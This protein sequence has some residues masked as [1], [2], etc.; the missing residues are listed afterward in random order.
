MTENRMTMINTIILLLISYFLL[1]LIIAGVP[2]AAETVGSD[3]P[4][5]Q[6]FLEALFQHNVDKL[7]ELFKNGL[8]LNENGFREVTVFG[9]N[10]HLSYL[11][12]AIWD[13]Q[14][15]LA[16]V[17]AKYHP[18]LINKPCGEDYSA[19]VYTPLAAAWAKNHTEL[20][21]ILKQNVSKAYNT[22]AH[23]PERDLTQQF[24]LSEKTLVN[25]LS[26]RK[27]SMNAWQEEVDW[28]MQH[29]KL[30]MEQKH[31]GSVVT[32]TTNVSSPLRVIIES[33]VTYQFSKAE[34]IHI[35]SLMD[36]LSTHNQYLL[37]LVAL[38][39]G[40]HT[41]A[42]EA[43]PYF[44]DIDYQ[45]PLGQSLLHVM[46]ITN[47]IKGIELLLTRHPNLELPNHIGVPPLIEACGAGWF[48]VV[49]L[50]ANHGAVIDAFY[51]NKH[52]SCIHIVALQGHYTIIEFLIKRGIPVD[53]ANLSGLRPIDCA[54]RRGHV[55]AT[56]LLLKRG[57]IVDR[58]TNGTTPLIKAMKSAWF[59]VVASLLEY[60]PNLEYPNSMIDTA[61]MHAVYNPKD[62]SYRHYRIIKLLLKAGAIPRADLDTINEVRS[63]EH[64][65][66]FYD[67]SELDRLSSREKN[68]LKTVPL[69]YTINGSYPELRDLLRQY[70]DPYSYEHLSLCFRSCYWKHNSGYCL[71]LCFAILACV[72]LFF[73]FEYYMKTRGGILARA[74]SAACVKLILMG[75]Q[76]KAQE[77]AGDYCK[78]TMYLYSAQFFIWEMYCLLIWLM[79]CFQGLFVRSAKNL[80]EQLWGKISIQDFDSTK[81]EIT[82]TM[83]EDEKIN[84]DEE[85]LTITKEEALSAV[86]SILREQ[87]INLTQK[88]HSI[89]IH[90][91]FSLKVF[92]IY[93][94]GLFC[95]LKKTWI[96]QQQ[97]VSQLNSLL[98]TKHQKIEKEREQKREEDKKAK[99]AMEDAKKLEAEEKQEKEKKKR[100]EDE[101][102]RLA[103]EEIQKTNEA[104]KREKERIKAQN[105]NQRRGHGNQA[106]GEQWLGDV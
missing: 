28:I 30:V 101:R 90:L 54:I 97:I 65:L 100:E 56:R 53:L 79:V 1:Y 14:I 46:A 91:S 73:D 48:G 89:Q 98:Q 78:W 61:L 36:S 104:A 80:L 47:N 86:L 20:F 27:P 44:R 51:E 40:H 41:L 83:T 39:T 29:P 43:Y 9:K 24:I 75:I 60:C 70:E 59:L 62:R 74:S 84:H 7:D 31:L 50:L 82:L 19:A 102:L 45:G 18:E 71:C 105:R 72:L 33:L 10:H 99:K 93:R 88:K 87:K 17:F 69:S 12:D 66:A 64:G 49:K 77:W 38:L 35:S 2:S 52:S 37:L 11:C 103:D 3:D 67:N 68:G 5:S 95:L 6:A 34:Q 4:I 13:N 94:Y 26:V 25:M 15:P 32:Q 16:L 81:P 85:I 23:V 58:L 55:Q 8:R 22:L 21:Q 57:A 76:T 96:T 42:G 63:S 92:F 106:V